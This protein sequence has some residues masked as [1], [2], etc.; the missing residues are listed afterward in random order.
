MSTHTATVNPW[1]PAPSRTVVAQRVLWLVI[2]IGLIVLTVM[3]CTANGGWTVAAAITGG[4]LP[5]VAFFVGA[6]QQHLQG[7]LPRAAVRTYNT[8]HRVWIPLGLLAVSFLAA[9]IAAEASAVG[10]ALAIAWLA[11]IAL[12]RAFG[13][14]LRNADGTR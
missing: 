1:S 11:H 12:D 14:G 10:I 6:G 3:Q 2:A 7:A 13:Y 5:D 9:G 8:L 4:L